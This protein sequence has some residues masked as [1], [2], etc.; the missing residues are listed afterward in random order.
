MKSRKLGKLDQTQNNFCLVCNLLCW[1]PCSRQFHLHLWLVQ[2]KWQPRNKR[3]S[4]GLVSRLPWS[5]RLVR[6]PWAANGNRKFSF[7]FD[8]FWHHRIC[9]GKSPD[10][11]TRV[12]QSKASSRNSATKGTVNFRLT[13]S[14]I[15]ISFV[16][17]LAHSLRLCSVQ[18]KW[19][20]NCKE[21]DEININDRKSSSLSSYELKEM[22]IYNVRYLVT[23]FHDFSLVTSFHWF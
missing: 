13:L 19:Y 12:F 10:I 6:D 9:N 23:L 16:R 1:N 3:E 17:G 8:A 7:S 21:L 11:K 4:D 20:L 22:G 5:G 15:N 2:R 14:V 18:W